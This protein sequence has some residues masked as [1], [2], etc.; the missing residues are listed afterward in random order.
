[1]SSAPLPGTMTDQLL[2]DLD[3]EAEGRRV[4]ALGA[5][6][7]GCSTG[8]DGVFIDQ[9]TG[10]KL[11][12][13]GRNVG[14]SRAELR[15]RRIRCIVQ[16]E[17]EGSLCPFSKCE[18]DDGKSFE[19]L[20]FPLGQW[21]RRSDCDAIAAGGAPTLDFFAPLFR[22]VQ[23]CLA[24]GDCVLVHCLAGAHRAGAA[25]VALLMELCD[26][27]YDEA[28]LRLQAKRPIV[29]PNGYL[30]ALLGAL[31]RARRGEEPL[32]DF[33]TRLALVK[34]FKFA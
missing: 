9:E 21:R 26:V 23:S 17:D 6:V 16:C 29:Q 13:G 18:A 20:R 31:E 24:R 14:F 7:Q 10:G 33:E 28:L 3:F 30:P 2:P 27:G 11:F 25:G 4:L 32:S 8:A 22:F 19:Y 5:L 12:V 34:G 15:A 1:M